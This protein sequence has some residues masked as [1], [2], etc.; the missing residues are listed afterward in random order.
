M[1]AQIRLGIVRMML[2]SIRIKITSHLDPIVCA[3]H[4]AM[5]REI[6]MAKNVARMAISTVSIK[7]EPVDFSTDRSGGKSR[8]GIALDS[9]VRL[10]R[11]RYPRFGY[12]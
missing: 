4:R 12:R 6:I 7:A 11:G 1:T 9:Q 2:S 10:G 5:K 8:K 3:A